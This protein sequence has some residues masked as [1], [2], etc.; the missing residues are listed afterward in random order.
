MSKP[1][2]SATDMRK[3][4]LEVPAFGALAAFWHVGVLPADREFVSRFRDALLL[5]V[6]H[7]KT[8]GGAGVVGP[9]R[10]PYLS[11]TSKRLTSKRL[12]ARARGSSADPRGAADWS[13]LDPQQ[14]KPGA[15]TAKYQSMFD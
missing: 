12:G 11:T 3:R 7:R 6:D 13:G 15:P 4:A 5:P 1:G 10:A 9:L 14:V 8:E 2:S